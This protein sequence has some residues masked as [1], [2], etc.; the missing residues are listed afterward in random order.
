MVTIES[1]LNQINLYFSIRYFKYS[2]DLNVI[3]RTHFERGYNLLP[4]IELSS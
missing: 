4:K 3:L 2:I 1:T